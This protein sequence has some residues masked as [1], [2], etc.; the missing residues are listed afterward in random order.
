MA[1]QAR[2]NIVAQQRL[3]LSI[4]SAIESFTAA[5]FRS[6]VKAFTGLDKAY[7][8]SGLQV[9]ATSGLTISIKVANSQVFNPLDSSGSFLLSPSDATDII[10]DL[11]ASQSNIFVEASFINMSK[12]PITASQWDPLAQN[13]D[14][15]AGFEFQASINSQNIIVMRITA[16]TVGP[17]PNAIPIAVISTDASKVT[18]MKDA[19]NG[20]FRLATGGVNAD[21]GNNFPF[22]A[23]RGE[24]VGSGTGVGDAQIVLLEKKT[25]LAF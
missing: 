24:S 7:I 6:I 9:T 2:E 20:M 3:D 19:R 21:A 16:N 8:L 14:S 10:V 1:V 23:T 4:L 5:D 15:P 11:P 12:A 25:G 17:T 13:G 18:N 22:S